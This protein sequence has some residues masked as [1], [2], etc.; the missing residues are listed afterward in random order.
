MK[1]TLSCRKL[2]RLVLGWII[3]SIE[4]ELFGHLAK[5][6]LIG[7]GRAPRLTGL[8]YKL[9][10]NVFVNYVYSVCVSFRV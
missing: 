9:K 1:N 5:S 3:D 6:P 8:H 10:M 2:H 7:I 4:V